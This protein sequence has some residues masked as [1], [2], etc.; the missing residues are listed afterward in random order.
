MEINTEYESKAITVS[1]SGD[2]DAVTAPVLEKTLSELIGT[3]AKPLVVNLEGVAYISSAGLRVILS[4]GKKMKTIEKPIL[5]T[6][7]NG[8][9]KK[10]FEISGFYAIFDI[11][12]TKWSAMERL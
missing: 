6:G 3:Y 10:V 5:L 11:F 4:T 1:V 12:D 8:A 2:L 7:L 9:V